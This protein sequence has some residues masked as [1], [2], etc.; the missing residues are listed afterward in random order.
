MPYGVS[1]VE[2]ESCKFAQCPRYLQELSLALQ[3]K[4]TA[5]PTRIHRLN[6]NQLGVAESWILH[7]SFDVWPRDDT[8]CFNISSPWL[9]LTIPWSMADLFCVSRIL[10]LLSDLAIV[11]I[12]EKFRSILKI[13]G[14]PK[15]ELLFLHWWKTSPGIAL[16]YPCLLLLL[17]PDELQY[18]ISCWIMKYHSYC[19]QIYE[20][21]LI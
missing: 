20:I 19:T 12:V 18:C 14:I 2:N 7:S 13:T 21:S 11:K 17:R 6:P 4:F 15:S 5:T 8:R 16:H 9:N 3:V 10:T 1:A